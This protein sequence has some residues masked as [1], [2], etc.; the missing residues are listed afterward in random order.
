MVTMFLVLCALMFVVPAAGA[1][2]AAMNGA[3]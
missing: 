1:N 3:P 2:W